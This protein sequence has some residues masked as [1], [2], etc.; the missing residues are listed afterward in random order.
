MAEASNKGI[1]KMINRMA[2]M[3][4]DSIPLVLLQMVDFEM[5]DALYQKTRIDSLF[6]G[7]FFA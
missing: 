1:E 7:F 3:I 2:L 4:E 5:I 6:P